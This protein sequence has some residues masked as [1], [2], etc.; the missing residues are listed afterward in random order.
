MKTKE[1]IRHLAKDSTLRWPFHRAFKLALAASL[2][3]TVLI[4]A[5]LV[6]P[7]PD[8]LQAADSTRFLFKFVVTLSTAT[9]AALLV[10]RQSQPGSPLGL[11]RLAPI[12]GPLLLIA[13]VIAELIA[14]PPSAWASLTIGSNSLMCLTLIPLLAAGPLFCIL[15]ALR[16]GAPTHPGVAGAT[17]GMLASAIAATFYASR[18]TDDS[19][20][21]VATWYPLASAFMVVTGY[22]IG[23]RMLRW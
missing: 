11:W 7:R 15:I 18:C 12:T 14:S 17:A 8:V 3:I 10:A 21:F 5:A 9:T 2:A 19:P 1:L 20:L 23:R 6:G 22:A 4:Y 13:A 16:H